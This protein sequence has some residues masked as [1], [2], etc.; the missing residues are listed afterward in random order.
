[1]NETKK[2]IDLGRIVADALDRSDLRRLV[3][4]DGEHGQRKLSEA[5]V[6][7]PKSYRQVTEFLTQ[8]SKDLHTELYNTEVKSLTSTSSKLDTTDMSS[9]EWRMQKVAETVHMNSVWLHEL[10]FANCFDPKSQV[11]VDSISYM[12]LERDCGGFEKWQKCFIACAESARD[13]WVVTGYNIFLRR[14]TTTFIDGDSMHVPVGFYPVVVLDM[15]E[16]AYVRDYMNDRKSYIV[17]MM[18]EINWTVVEERMDKAEKIAE[19]LK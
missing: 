4:P 3:S 13:G 5:Y 15:H 10:F 7:E 1:M 8:R 6:A 11:Y 19:V 2:N 17:A 9:P 16:H 14:Y 12:R 18:R